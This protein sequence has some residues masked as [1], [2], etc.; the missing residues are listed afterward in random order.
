[1]LNPA[2]VGEGSKHDEEK[3]LNWAYILREIFKVNVDLLFMERAVG[4]FQQP[5]L[6]YLYNKANKNLLYT[7]RSLELLVDF[8]EKSYIEYVFF[9]SIASFNYYRDDVDLLVERSGYEVL[10]K[11]LEDNGFVPSAD[12]GNTVH[13]D[14]DG[15]VQIDVHNVIN[16]G[17]LGNSG[18]GPSIMDEKGILDSREQKSYLGVELYTPCPEYEVLALQAHS[19]FQHGYLTLG[20]ILFTG[21]LIRKSGFDMEFLFA[22][23][24]KYNWEELL[25]SNLSLINSIY[26]KFWNITLIEEMPAKNLSQHFKTVY[27]V[28]G[29]KNIKAKFFAR[30]SNSLLKGVTN[31]LLYL[32]RATKYNLLKN[33]LAF[34]CIPPFVIKRLQ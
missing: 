8:L 11:Y 12:S 34:N 13:F 20:E 17:Y 29:S 7:K 6:L 19:I 10:K 14:K 23:S 27:G 18:L 28:W 16:W 3:D 30:A 26:S 25:R 32:Y 31:L 9:K 21:E 22:E 4:Y 24:K 1:M 5:D 33:E 15:Y 2:F